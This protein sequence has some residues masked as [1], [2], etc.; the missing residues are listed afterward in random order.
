MESME[1]GDE[2][3]VFAGF[4]SSGKHCYLVSQKDDLEGRA[5]SCTLQTQVIGV[6]EEPVPYFCKVGKKR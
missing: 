1:R 4:M 3:Y 2:V 6:R 5:I